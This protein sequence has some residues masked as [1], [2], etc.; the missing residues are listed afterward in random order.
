MTVHLT[1][2]G[3]FE[4]VSDGERL[5]E[6]VANQP[7]TATGGRREAR[8]GVQHVDGCAARPAAFVN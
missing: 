8:G 4:A 1:H 2:W 3:A 6:L 7:A 5:T